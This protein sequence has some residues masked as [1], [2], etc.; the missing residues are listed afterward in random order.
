MAFKDKFKQCRQEKNVSQK[1]LATFFNVAQTTISKWEKGE[2]TPNY[3]MLK[4]IAD[5][6][7]VNPNYFLVESTEKFNLQMFNGN[8]K[9]HVDQ[10]EILVAN[11]I[12]HL[13]TLKDEESKKLTLQ[14]M[15][16]VIQLSI[17][18]LEAISNLIKTMKQ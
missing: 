16:D 13:L 10:S 17:P 2:R 5:Y 15:K 9:Y 18:Q 7:Q 1:E 6:F 12:G 8:V 11:A 14:I 4:K 3:E